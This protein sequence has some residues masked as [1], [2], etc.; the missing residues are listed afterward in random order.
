MTVYATYTSR[1]PACPIHRCEKVR[2]SRG[3]LCPECLVKEVEQL[4]E[5]CDEVLRVAREN[6]Y[7]AN[8]GILVALLEVKPDG[9]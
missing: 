7:T 4:S 2:T 8:V 1:V 3:F 9:R 6:N 5:A